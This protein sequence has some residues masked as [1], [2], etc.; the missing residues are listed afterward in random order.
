[1]SPRC[2]LS[3]PTTGAPKRAFQVRS[4]LLKLSALWWKRD[5]QSI[6]LRPSEAGLQYLSNLDA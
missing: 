2:A 5:F 4:T 6:C 3:S 1:M